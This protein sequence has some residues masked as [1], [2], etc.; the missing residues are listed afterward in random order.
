MRLTKTFRHKHFE[1]SVEPNN[2]ITEY[3]FFTSEGNVYAVDQGSPLSSILLDIYME[4]IK[5]EDNT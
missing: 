4:H 3:N 5:G 1:H 2:L